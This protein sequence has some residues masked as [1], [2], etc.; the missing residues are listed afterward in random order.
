MREE[1][2]LA[3]IQTLV[4]VPRQLC[5]V[6]SHVHFTSCVR[7]IYSGRIMW[8]YR[9]R[10]WGGVGDG[11]S[12]GP[13]AHRGPRRGFEVDSGSVRQSH[14]RSINSLQRDLKRRRELASS[15][16][17]FSLSLYICLFQLCL[18]VFFSLVYVWITL[19]AGTHFYFCFHVLTQSWACCSVYSVDTD[20]SVCL[21]PQRLY[22]INDES[23]NGSVFVSSTVTQRRNESY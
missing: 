19:T 10:A 1:A 14:S 23:S 18:S 21:C 2:A 4:G 22:V 9:N 7:M 5:R 11:V 17:S 16:L 13:G 12:A 3:L 15:P 20:E 6:L 8:R